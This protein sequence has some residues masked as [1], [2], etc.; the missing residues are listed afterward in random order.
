MYEDLHDWQLKSD[1]LEG[2]CFAAHNT[3]LKFISKG[4]PSLC[5]LDEAQQCFTGKRN[6]G[7]QTNTLGTYL[8]LALT[9]LLSDMVSIP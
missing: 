7:D 9:L 5:L 3:V 1:E 6:I 4:V 8:S 2:L